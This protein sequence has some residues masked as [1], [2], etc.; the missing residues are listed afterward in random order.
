MYQV[1]EKKGS[2]RRFLLLVSLGQCPPLLKVLY[3][4]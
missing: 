4:G 3:V 2:D 1:L